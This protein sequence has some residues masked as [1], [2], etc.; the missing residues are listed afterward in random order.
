M[1]SYGLEKLVNFSQILVFPK[2][3]PL[4]LSSPITDEGRMG[5]TSMDF[6]LETIKVPLLATGGG[7]IE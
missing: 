4:R 3:S 1:F 5:I 2:L 6:L 7:R